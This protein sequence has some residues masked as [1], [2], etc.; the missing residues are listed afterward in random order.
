MSSLYPSFSSLSLLSHSLALCVLLVF[1]LLYVLVLYLSPWPSSY[2]LVIVPSFNESLIRYHFSTARTDEALDADAD[3]NE[4]GEMVNIAGEWKVRYAQSSGVG[5]GNVAGCSP[6]VLTQ[7][8]A[9]R[10]V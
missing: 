10:C 7:S 2:V 9:W 4:E 1:L 5:R 8:Q 6:T 3:G